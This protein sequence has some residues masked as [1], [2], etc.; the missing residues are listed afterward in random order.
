MDEKDLLRQL[1]KEQVKRELLYEGLIVSYSPSFIFPR[2]KNLGFNSVSYNKAQSV[3][4][5]N[6]QLDKNNKERYNELNNFLKNVCGWEHGATKSNNQIVPSKTDF[7]DV[8]NGNAILQYEAKFNLRAD[9]IPDK[10]YHLTT[11]DKCDKILS[12]GLT[13][14]SSFRF[15]NFTD[16]VYLSLN[17]DALTSFA[18]QKSNITEKNDFVILEINGNKLNPNMR[19]FKDPNFINGIYTLENIP[20][21]AIKV[22][23]ELNVD[24]NNITKTAI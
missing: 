23:F 24:G 5:I 13:P 16:R 14:K 20:P 7:L 1:I 3:F 10:L 6:F 19:F 22:V 4:N 21:Q 12:N 11:K 2:L 18:I 9:N 15:F 8:E 17:I